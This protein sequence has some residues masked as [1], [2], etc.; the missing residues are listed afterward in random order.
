MW[1]LEMSHDILALHTLH[2]LVFLTYEPGHEGDIASGDLIVDQLYVLEFMYIFDTADCALVFVVQVMIASDEVHWHAEIVQLL[3]DLQAGIH[4]LDVDVVAIMMEIAQ[5]DHTITLP[6]PDHVQE[7]GH[8][9]LTICYELMAIAFIAQVKVSK[10][11]RTF[12]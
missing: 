5:E 7:P 9:I 6:G 3:Q 4:G 11:S 1:Q 2:V 8:V 10:H 12:E